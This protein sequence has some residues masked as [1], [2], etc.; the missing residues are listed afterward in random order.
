MRALCLKSM[1]NMLFWDFERLMIVEIKMT[2]SGAKRGRCFRMRVG[3]QCGDFVV[4]GVGGRKIG[5]ATMCTLWQKVA[6]TKHVI[7]WRGVILVEHNTLQ[8]GHRE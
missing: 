1:F 2:A 3:G 7:W 5:G 6:V 8:G 4:R